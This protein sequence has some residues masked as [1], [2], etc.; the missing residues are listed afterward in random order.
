MKPKRV[1]ETLL[2]VKESLEKISNKLGFRRKLTF[3]GKATIKKKSIY[4][5]SCGFEKALLSYGYYF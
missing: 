3:G 5:F 2:A 1:Q 4:F